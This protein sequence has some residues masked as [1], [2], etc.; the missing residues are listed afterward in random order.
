MLGSSLLTFSNPKILITSSLKSAA[1]VISIRWLGTTHSKCPLSSFVSM[2]AFLNDEIISSS[3]KEVPNLALIYDVEVFMIVGSYLFLRYVLISPTS[4]ASAKSF[5]RR[6][7]K[8]I[9]STY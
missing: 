8:F 7:V 2:K 5:N 9:T 3:L 4:L 6:A 1:P